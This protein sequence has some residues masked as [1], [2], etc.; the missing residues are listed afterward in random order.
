MNVEQAARPGASTGAS[1]RTNILVY[2]MD[3]AL[4]GSFMVSICLGVM[5][6]E[7]PAS[8][9]RQAIQSELLRHAL[10][11][12]LVGV[13]ASCLIYSPWGKRSG[14]SMNPA[15]TLCF[16][17]LGQLGPRAALGYVVA[18][19]VG[20]ALGVA[21]CSVIFRQWL[22][23][24]AVD[25]ALTAPGP[26]GIAVA[27]FA[28]FVIAFVM[29][30]AVLVVNQVP[31][32][33]ARTGYLAATLLALYVTFELPL[34]GTSLNPARSFASALFAWSW[35]TFWIYLTAPVAG[36]LLAVELHPRLGTAS[37]K[38]CAKVNHDDAVECFVRCDCVTAPAAPGSLRP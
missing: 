10:L 22:G 25:F 11:G 34:S 23:H 27:W 21:A 26:D 37:E 9:V 16:L 32:F 6:L 31:R 19:F 4:L 17:R 2:A 8:P 7:H 13:T 18:E 15:M 1:T 28:E 36:M 35:S 20:G 14:A 33:A 3:G 30:Y 12:L 24:P 5:L 38:A 29:L